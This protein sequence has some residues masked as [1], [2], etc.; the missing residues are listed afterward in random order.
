MGCD[1]ISVSL[2]VFLRIIPPVFLAASVVF[3]LVLWPFGKP[4]HLS[5]W[6]G[7]DPRVACNWI[8][9]RLYGHSFFSRA[10]WFD[11]ILLILP[12]PNVALI[13]LSGTG[14]QT[15]GISRKCGKIQANRIFRHTGIQACLPEFAPPLRC[16][17][18]CLLFLDP[19]FVGNKRLTFIWAKQHNQMIQMSVFRPKHL[20]SLLSFV[21]SKDFRFQDFWGWGG[22]FRLD[23]GFLFRRTVIDA[24]HCMAEPPPNN[25]RMPRLGVVVSALHGTFLGFSLPFFFAEKNLQNNCQGV[26]YL[27]LLIPPKARLLLGSGQ[28]QRLDAQMGEIEDR[29]RLL[30]SQARRVAPFD[31]K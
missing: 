10:G 30:H 5:G 12:S 26:W 27:C 31:F 21:W 4:I 29:L 23:W 14:E 24:I 11:S 16:L 25:H 9:K 8:T 13:F 17:S 6:G 2:P 22:M 1:L 15:E 28:R 19:L 3:S 7:V 20:R 18:V